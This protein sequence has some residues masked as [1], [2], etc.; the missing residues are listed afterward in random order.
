MATK[1]LQVKF[2]VQDRPN[3]VKTVQDEVTVSYG[4][5]LSNGDIKKALADRWPNL[6]DIVSSKEVK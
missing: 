2:T 3:H 5:Y 4:G 6:R 1:R